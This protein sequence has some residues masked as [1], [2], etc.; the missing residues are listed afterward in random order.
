MAEGVPD[1]DRVQKQSADGPFPHEAEFVFA[2]VAVHRRGERARRH[3]VFDEGKTLAG[4]GDIHEEPGAY[5][6]QERDGA[7]IRPITFGAEPII[8]VLL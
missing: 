3:R 4:F 2:M 7:I 5:A 1:H 8:D 6:P